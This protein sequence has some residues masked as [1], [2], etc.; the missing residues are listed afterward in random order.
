M[1]TVLAVGDYDPTFGISNGVSFIGFY[2]VDKGYY[3]SG[4]PCFN[5]EGDATNTFL[6]NRV[7]VQKSIHDI[8]SVR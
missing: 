1:D 7:L 8:I 5:I 6:N 3:P 2:V 4:S